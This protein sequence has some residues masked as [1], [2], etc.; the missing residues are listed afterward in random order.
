[1]IPYA[2]S[3]VLKSAHP[4]Y[5]LI[6]RHSQILANLR[7][8]PSVAPN[9]NAMAATWKCSIYSATAD[10]IYVVNLTTPYIEKSL[11]DSK[12]TFLDMI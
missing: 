6:T 7:M 12:N 11:L 2:S 4:E 5:S 3:K 1:M 8:K 9:P 10:I